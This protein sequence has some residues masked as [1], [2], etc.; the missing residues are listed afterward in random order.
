MIRRV[1]SLTPEFIIVPD[2]AMNQKRTSGRSTF[3][4]PSMLHGL[5]YVVDSITL[6]ADGRAAMKVA[7]GLHLGRILSILWKKIHA[8]EV[9]SVD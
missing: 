9:N 3:I 4:S 6:I 1:A 7:D 2:I 5:S 8:I